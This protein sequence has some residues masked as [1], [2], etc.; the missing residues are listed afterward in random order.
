MNTPQISFRVINEILN[1]IA[2]QKN[3]DISIS[4]LKTVTFVHTRLLL[5]IYTRHKREPPME[6]VSRPESIAIAHMLF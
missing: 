4:E 3:R 6:I 2:G 5:F 1:E